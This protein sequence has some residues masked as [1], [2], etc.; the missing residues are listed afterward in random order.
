MTYIIRSNGSYLRK[1]TFGEASGKL[2]TRIVTRKTRI[3]L[4]IGLFYTCGS[5]YIFVTYSAVYKNSA[6]ITSK[7]RLYEILPVDLCT[8]KQK[9]WYFHSLMLAPIQKSF[10]NEK[11]NYFT[12]YSYILSM[13]KRQ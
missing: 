12:D 8:W 6:F 5:S 9:I 1:F 7:I 4:K 11:F 13:F 2:I 3:F 10:C